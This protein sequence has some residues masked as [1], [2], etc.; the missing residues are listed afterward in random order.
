MEAGLAAAL[1]SGVLPVLRSTA[2]ASDVATV[3]C[4]ATTQR[5]SRA[6]IMMQR[7][8]Q[9][10]TTMAL[11]MTFCTFPRKRNS[12]KATRQRR[13]I[14]PRRSVAT[15]QPS[16]P[17]IWLDRTSQERLKGLRGTFSSKG[18]GARGTQNATNRVRDGIYQG[19]DGAPRCPYNVR[20]LGEKQDKAQRRTP[21]SRPEVG[22]MWWRGRLDVICV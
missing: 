8:A 10:A 5:S 21:R 18:W 22:M 9:T 3:A 16:N 20:A 2:T 19:L 12:R 4:A 6:V 15:D 11:Q 7:E 17:Q 14:F 1:A 13:R